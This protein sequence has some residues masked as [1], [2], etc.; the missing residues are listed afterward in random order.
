MGYRFP[1][2]LT[3]VVAVLKWRVWLRTEADPPDLQLP[4]GRPV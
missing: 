4:A 3:P 1:N 2:R